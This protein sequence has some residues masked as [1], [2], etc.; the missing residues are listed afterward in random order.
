MPALE[1]RPNCELCDRDLPPHSHEARICSK[2]CTWCADC[3]ENVLHNVCPNC[4]GEM[5]RRPIRPVE[6]YRP[7]EGLRL[8]PAGTTRRH[9]KYTRPQIDEFV[10][11][12]KD[13]P[14]DRR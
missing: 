9:T 11:G 3:A 14:P 6:A 2:E 13:I 10:A 4:G 1:I 12:L 8:N 7:G 5:V